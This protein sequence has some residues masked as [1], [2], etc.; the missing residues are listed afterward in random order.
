MV[1]YFS[2]F[3][4]HPRGMEKSTSYFMHTLYSWLPTTLM[5]PFENYTFLQGN[6]GNGK[7]Q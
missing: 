5:Y 4:R 6:N 1:H 7:T 2:F 3:S